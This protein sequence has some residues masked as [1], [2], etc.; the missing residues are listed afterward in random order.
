MN[1]ETA[2]NLDLPRS[3]TEGSSLRVLLSSTNAV[4]SLSIH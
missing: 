2:M 1:W 4:G 3:D